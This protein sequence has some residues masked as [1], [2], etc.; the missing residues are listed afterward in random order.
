M[1]T[2][3]PDFVKIRARSS[4]YT[5]T[6]PEAGQL[7]I[8]CTWIGAARKHIVKCTTAYQKIAPEARILLIELDVQ[9]ITSRCKK[10]R[11]LIKS[12]VLIVLDTLA[13]SGCYDIL[14]DSITTGK[15]SHKLRSSAMIQA[16]PKIL[17][18]MF[19]N[20]STNRAT[21]FLVFFHERL[22]QPL[23]I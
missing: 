20:G 1:A 14:G 22:G 2:L 9:I 18:Y 8:I 23:P 3:L 13:E 10:Q 5:P 12:G 21:Q 6:N 7:I 16:P 19:S 15:P 4:L 17:L 11:E